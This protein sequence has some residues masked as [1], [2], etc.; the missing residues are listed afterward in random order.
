[1]PELDDGDFVAM[2]RD[3]EAESTAPGND[4]GDGA[5]GDADEDIETDTGGTEDVS[6]GEGGGADGS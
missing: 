5:D 4:A 6:R 1:M 3:I 2:V